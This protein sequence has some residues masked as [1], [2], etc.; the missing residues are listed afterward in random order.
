MLVGLR[1]LSA[2]GNYPLGQFENI[3]LYH[4]TIIFCISVVIDSRSIIILDFIDEKIF[5]CIK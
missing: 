3:I 1:L 4:N 2:E 5:M